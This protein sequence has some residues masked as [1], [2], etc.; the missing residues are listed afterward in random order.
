MICRT[1][2]TLMRYVMRF[3]ADKSVQLYRCPV[4]YYESKTT[5]LIF[6]DTKPRNKTN[7]NK[8]KKKPLKKKVRIRHR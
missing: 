8:N 7:E 1:C 4:C 3:E 6:T 2:N 5:P